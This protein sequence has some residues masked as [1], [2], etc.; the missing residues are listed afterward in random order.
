MGASTHIWRADFFWLWSRWEMWR[1]FI[2]FFNLKGGELF[3]FVSQKVSVDTVGVK[4][5]SK[6][7]IETFSKMLVMLICKPFS[8]S[9]DVFQNIDHQSVSYKWLFS[10]KLLTAAL[11]LG[12]WQARNSYRKLLDHRNMVRRIIGLGRDSW[13]QEGSSSLSSTNEQND[14]Q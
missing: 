12:S 3:S 4:I 8:I 14:F 1:R 9:V 6:C 11:W 5:N 2:E 13:K 10:Y 7:R